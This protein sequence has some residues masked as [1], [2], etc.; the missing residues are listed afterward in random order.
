M[1]TDKVFGRKRS[2]WMRETGSCIIVTVW[3]LAKMKY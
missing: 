3:I 1:I 2:Q